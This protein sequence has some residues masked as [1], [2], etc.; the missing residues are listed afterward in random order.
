MLRSK[1]T[2]SYYRLIGG[3]SPILDITNAQA[4]A[5]EKALNGSLATRDEGQRTKLS[6]V[7]VSKAN[8]RLSSIVSGSTSECVTGI[9]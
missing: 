8:G 4:K 7:L 2:E 9:L 1:K 3:R 5:L 6:I